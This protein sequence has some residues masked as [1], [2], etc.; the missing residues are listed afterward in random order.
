MSLTPLPPPLG[1]RGALLTR[2]KRTNSMGDIRGGEI[3]VLHHSPTGML[4]IKNDQL[5][6]TNVFTTYRLVST[7]QG[8]QHPPCCVENTV[9]CSLPCL[10]RETEGAVCPPPTTSPHPSPHHVSTHCPPCPHPP[11]IETMPVWAHFRCSASVHHLTRRTLKKCP[12]GHGFDAQCLSTILNIE[13]MPIWA[14]FHNHPEHRNCAHLG[15]FSMLCVCPPLPIRRTSKKCPDGHGFDARRLSTTSPAKTDGHVSDALRVST[16]SPPPKHQNHAHLDTV[17]MLGTRPPLLHLPNIEKMLR[18]GMVSMLGI[19][20][21]SCPPHPYLPN[22][23][24]MPTWA[25]F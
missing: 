3:G 7:R 8:G 19:Y 2:H 14:H 18:M 16:T 17:S 5:L 11:N 24:K 4:F 22:I 15:T 9:L 6:C 20:S 25:C 12:D 13:I 23:E 1:C 21:L 10:K